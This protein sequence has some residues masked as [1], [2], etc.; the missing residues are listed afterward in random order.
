M[1]DKTD[2]VER[3][4]KGAVGMAGITV[5]ES[6]E[7]AD[8]IERLR[9]VAIEAHKLTFGNT[10]LESAADEWD[11][12]ENALQ[13]LFDYDTAPWLRAALNGKEG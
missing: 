8:E 2:I 13:E 6:L 7:A 3:L 1:T 12:I 5:A 4:R 9:R 10:A 11:A